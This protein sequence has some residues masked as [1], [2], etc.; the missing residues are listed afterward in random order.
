[1][2][3]HS[4]CGAAGSAATTIS[5]WT[6]KKKE[7]RNELRERGTDEKCTLER[8][9]DCDCDWLLH[10][11]TDSTHGAIGRSFSAHCQR[12]LRRSHR[13]KMQ[14]TI[15][16]F[17]PFV[18]PYEYVRVHP[19]TDGRGGEA[20]CSDG[21]LIFSSTLR[22]LS[23]LPSCLSPPRVSDAALEMVINMDLK[24]PVKV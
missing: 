6:P 17:A 16:D 7:R 14:Q 8:R 3:C 20:Q 19:P 5:Q 15:A 10:H 22:S 2:S 23:P 24:K 12:R 1:M 18:R 4:P 13:Q 11:L 21:K 9:L